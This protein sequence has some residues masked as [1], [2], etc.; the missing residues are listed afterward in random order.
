MVWEA[1]DLLSR[2]CVASPLAHDGLVY[3]MS[4][5]GLFVV[6]DAAT[7]KLVYK[8]QFRQSQAGGRPS[9]SL[10]GGHV[11]LSWTNGATIVVAAG[12]EFRQ[13]SENKVEGYLRSSPIA[14]LPGAQG[15]G[16]GLRRLGQEADHPGGQGQAEGEAV[17]G[18]FTELTLTGHPAMFA[19]TGKKLEWDVKKMRCTNVPDINQY[20]GRTYRK[21]WEV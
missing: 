8:Q 18:A 12:R 21:G 14:V 11:F 19:G 20:V 13:V 10:A 9:L 4:E 2:M 15:R 3:A 1:K 5:M 16:V 7:G 6:L 17:A